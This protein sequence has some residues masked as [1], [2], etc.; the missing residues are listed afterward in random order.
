MSSKNK[1]LVR[2]FYEDIF[3]RGDVSAADEIVAVNYVNHNP[4]P[5]AQPGRAGLK[6]F[7]EAFRK[8]LSSIKFTIEKQAVETSEDLS[9]TMTISTPV[10]ET[11]DQTMEESESPTG[12][13]S[14]NILGWLPLVLFAGLVAHGKITKKDE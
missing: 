11:D 1:E 13:N 7:A 12:S 2:R 5:G 8:A 10:P 4:P 6:D 3:N 9:G 14:G